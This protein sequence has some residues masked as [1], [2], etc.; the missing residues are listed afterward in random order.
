MLKNVKY[1]IILMLKK[2][3]RP[4]MLPLFCFVI[5]SSFT[6]AE[7][8]TATCDQCVVKGPFGGTLFSCKSV[9]NENC[10]YSKAGYTLSCANA[11]KC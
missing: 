5:T 8:V 1:K 10:S 6:E 2:I 7:E 11:K 4:V 9:A 3:L